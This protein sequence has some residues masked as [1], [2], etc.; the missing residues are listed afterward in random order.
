M[1]A[2][3][4][5]YKA[6]KRKLYIRIDVEHDSEKIAYQLKD[7]LLKYHGK[8]NVILYRVKSKQENALPAQYNAEINSNLIEQLKLLLGNSNIV[9]R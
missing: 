8:S 6:K 2:A 5:V 7:I 1:I 9:V 4:V 3:N